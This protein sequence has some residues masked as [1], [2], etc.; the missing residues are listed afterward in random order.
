MFPSRDIS[1]FSPIALIIST[2]RCSILHLTRIPSS[3]PD[4]LISIN[5]LRCYIRHRRVIIPVCSDRFH[6]LHKTDLLWYFH[7]SLFVDNWPDLRNN[8][9]CQFFAKCQPLHQRFNAG[10]CAR[11]PIWW[12]RW[13]CWWSIYMYSRGDDDDDDDVRRRRQEVK[14]LGAM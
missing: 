4:S 12:R 5:S 9:W 8:W 14:R 3:I 1:A 13:L 6:S 2:V 7:F 11:L 10:W